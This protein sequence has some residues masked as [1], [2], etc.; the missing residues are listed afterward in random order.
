MSERLVPR[1]PRVIRR[2]LKGIMPHAA[3]KRMHNFDYH[4]S[5][6]LSTYQHHLST[7]DS[8]SKR[9]ILAAIIESTRKRWKGKTI[10]CYPALPG[11]GFVFYRLSLELGYTFT[12]NTKAD[13]DLAIKW[14]V[15]T[16][17]PAL[18]YFPVESDH[19][20]NKDAEDF[21]KSTVCHAF[22]TTFGYP[23]AVNPRAHK[24]PMVRKSEENAAHDG[25]IIN[26]PLEEPEPGFVY[27][28]LINC[29]TEEGVTEDIRVPIFGDQ[30]PFVYLRYKDKSNRFGHAGQSV[31]SEQV[32]AASNVFSN[33][34]I[35]NILSFCKKLGLDCGELDVLRDRTEDRIYIVDANVTPTGPS[36]QLGPQETR[37]VCKKMAD[38]FVQEFG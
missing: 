23:L 21:R 18:G 12:Q 8:G 34:E 1:V 35:D 25:Q 16:K 6:F 33:R 7:I 38:A 4:L 32:E 36:F 10:F 11:P 13:F 29:E 14:W 26:G 17:D 9:E 30:I 22:R 2:A 31:I 24:G 20:I 5:H 15:G 37:M 19:V 27:Q 28:K 3:R